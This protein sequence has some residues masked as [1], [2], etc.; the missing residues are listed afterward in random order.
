MNSLTASTGVSPMKPQPFNLV[1]LEVVG[2]APAMVIADEVLKDGALN[3]VGIEADGGNQSLIKLTGD[4]ASCQRAAVTAERIVARMGGQVTTAVR[5]A[6]AESPGVPMVVTPQEYSPITEGNLHVLP[7]AHGKKGPDMQAIGILETQ[8]L[9]A[10]I[11]GADAMLKAAN[12]EVVGKEKIGGA[13]VTVFIRG[14]VAAVKAAIEAGSAAASKVGKLV[15]AHV[16]ARPHD[17]LAR[18][19]P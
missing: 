7:K 13:H 6:Y 17:G 10:V 15:A 19:L 8:G 2:L 4:V 9:T 14:D 1:T 3:L 5:P 16:I 18:L 12:V 11:E